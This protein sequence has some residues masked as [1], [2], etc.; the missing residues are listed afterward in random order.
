MENKTHLIRLNCHT[1]WEVFGC[2]FVYYTAQKCGW[3]IP[4]RVVKVTAWK[5]K[6]TPSKLSV[7]NLP[8]A[9]DGDL[10][11]HFFPP[12]LRVST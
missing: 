2:Q 4:E 9:G 12:S 3:K 11:S 8:K 1:Q 10:R 7:I 6:T 5:D